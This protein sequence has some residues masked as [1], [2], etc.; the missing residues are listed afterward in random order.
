MATA[1]RVKPEK[2]TPDFAL[3][4][5]A[6]GQWCK[7]IR[8]KLYYFGPWDDPEGALNKYLDQK[9]DLQAGRKPRAAD[10]GLTVRELCNKFLT[11]KRHLIDTREL[12]PR[13]FADYK[14]ATDRIIEEFGRHRLVS[15]LRSDDFQQLRA[16]LAKGR[17]VISLGNAVR[18]IRIVFRYASENDLI[19]RPVKFGTA[20][21]EPAKKIKRR[22]EQLQ[23]QKHGA[24]MFEA[25]EIRLLLD[26][27]NGKSVTIARIDEE[28][29]RPTEL[30]G[31][32]NPVLRSMILLAI[33]G[34]LGQSDL[35]NLP[36][37][38]LDLKRAWL[39]YPR[40]KTAVERQVPLWP[41]TVKALENAL[42]ARPAPKEDEDQGLVFI[43]LRGHRWVRVKE[44]QNENGE[45]KHTPIDAV[46]EEF[47][48]VLRILEL[49]RVRLNFYGLRHT[50]R[51]VADETHDEPAIDLIMGHTAEADDMG[52]KYRERISDERLKAVVNHVHAWLFPPKRRAKMAK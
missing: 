39:N 18:H 37:S 31:R 52:A 33:N 46:A 24:R 41:E 42:G 20:F 28:T 50:F 51:T 44:T 23:R 3:F 30:E 9:D 26:Y 49:K 45:W 38:A 1:Q 22:A 43:T 12:S 36:R 14:R 15:D 40:V 19:D 21:R 47:G 5:H 4:A 27:V 32:E 11:W 34:G 29:G 25:E 16:K 48:K 13:T 7:K 6:N 17:D 8:R 10:D 35:A 2:P